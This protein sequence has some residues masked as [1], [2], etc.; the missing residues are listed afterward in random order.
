VN[1]IQTVLFDLGNVLAYIDFSAF[2]RDLGFLRAEE[3][4]PFRDGYTALTLQYET[5]HISTDDYLNG[6]RT[7]FNNKFTIVQLEQAFSCI[8][9]QP[10][11][12][13]TDIVKRVSTINQTALV[14]NTNE[15]H[16]RLSLKKFEGLKI[17]QKHYLSYQLRVMKPARGFYDAIIKDQGILPSKMLFIDDIAE[18]VKAAKSAGMQIIQF[19]STEQLETDLEKLGIL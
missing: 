11:E 5:G 2:W 1:Q 17:L 3:I 4:V 15:I 9:K 6:L 7:V 16:Y 14:S 13:I 8:I 19:E 10:V 12:G 18:N